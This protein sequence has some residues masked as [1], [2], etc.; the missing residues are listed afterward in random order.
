MVIIVN[1]LLSAVLLEQD[2]HCR[3]LLGLMVTSKPQLGGHYPP[4]ANLQDLDFSPFVSLVD[5]AALHIA[6]CSNVPQV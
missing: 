1:I 5:I 3:N 2:L 4:N 6:A